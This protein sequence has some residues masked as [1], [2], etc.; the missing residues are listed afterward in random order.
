MKLAQP[1]FLKSLSRG[2]GVVVA[3]VVL[4]LAVATTASAQTPGEWKYTI[5]TDLSSVPEDMRV[6]FPTVSFKAC[7]SAEDF[8]SGRAFA[9]QTLASSETRCPSSR[10][11]RKP[12]GNADALNFEFACD[13]GKTLRGSAQGRVRAKQF[14]LALLTEFPTSVSGVS[15]V[16]QSMRGE[17]TGACKVKPDRDEV[18]VP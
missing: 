6:N 14:E 11:Q 13:E 5:S 15:S 16:K 7:R 4:A 18:K 8:A 12:S 17:Y 2:S 9:L 1:F 3:K 10:F